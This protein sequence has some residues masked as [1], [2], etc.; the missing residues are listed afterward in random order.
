MAGSDSW[1]ADGA[2]ELHNPAN[3]SQ[4]SRVRTHAA[5]AY[6][7]Y[8]EALREKDSPRPYLIPITVAPSPGRT[9]DTP[10][11]HI[12]ALVVVLYTIH[13]LGM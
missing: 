2:V 6:L 1:R 11:T 13:N 9:I 3:A 10:F 8:L 12:H 7:R 4:K 5:C